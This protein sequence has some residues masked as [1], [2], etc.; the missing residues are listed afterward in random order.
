M[1]DDLSRREYESDE[2]WA[3]RG[4]LYQALRN[5]TAATTG[6]R[7]RLE[8]G[9]TPTANAL[10]QAVDDYRAAVARTCGEGMLV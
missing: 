4:A 3:A 9:S 1:S 6:T 8:G 5:H 2:E 10:H 7:K